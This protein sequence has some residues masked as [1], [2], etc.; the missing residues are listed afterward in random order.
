MI[1]FEHHRVRSR[2]EARLLANGDRRGSE[3]TRFK[4]DAIG[5]LDGTVLEIGAGTGVNLRWYR[6]GAT[7]IAIE[8]NPIMREH[9]AA[10]NAS[11]EHPVELEIRNRRGEQLDLADGAADAAVSTLVLCGVDDPVA[12]LEEVRRVVR[13]GGRLVFVEHVAA[14]IGSRTARA[15]RLVRR[16]HHW[17]FNGCRV[18]QDTETL[19]RSFEWTDLDLRHVDLGRAGAYVRHQIIGTATR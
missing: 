2:I 8:P 18:D 6:P 19:L 9:L 12:V 14:P 11:L 1:D 5:A 4:A 16:P 17:M 7:V 10:T 3:V 13:P 15:Q